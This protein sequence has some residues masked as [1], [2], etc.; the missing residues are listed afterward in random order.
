MTLSALTVFVVGLVALVVLIVGL[1]AY[2][3]ANRL[4]RLHVRSDLSW[5]A[6][7]ASLAR[8]S[9]VVRALAA[10][11]PAG[12]R[13]PIVAAADAA[14]RADRGDRERAENALSAVLAD[15]DTETLRPQLVA[16][17]ADAEA[18]VLIARRFHNDAVRDTLALRTR[19]LVR[20]L[21]LGGTAPLPVYFEI[22]ERTSAAGRV[23]GFELDATRTS[24]RVVVL[25]DRGR[26][27][28]LRGRDP[29][30][31]GVH[32]WFTVGGAVEKSETLREAAVRELAEET[33]LRADPAALRG[34]MW[35]RVA[36]FSWNGELIRSEEFFFVLPV[37]EFAPVSD[38]FT[39][40][41]KRTITDARWCDADGIRA[42]DAAGETV[43]PRDLADSLREAGEIAAGVGDVHVRQIA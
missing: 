4:D 22:S 10:T 9:A 30:V 21:H 23:E 24:A 42:L 27:L 37:P 14:E 29:A 32:F 43:Y 19:R 3:T 35:R 12:R 8:R 2:G 41:E 40:V 5:Q 28:L 7:D 13:R 36:V 1:W 11:L 15:L 6:L 17:L 31:E 25:D 18:R 39:E 20:W 34:P 16:E 26:V 38:G 33:G